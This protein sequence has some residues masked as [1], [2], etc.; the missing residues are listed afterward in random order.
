MTSVHGVD[1]N[2][3]LPLLQAELNTKTNPNGHHFCGRLGLFWF[4]TRFTKKSDPPSADCEYSLLRRMM[5]ML[6][7]N[8]LHLGT[9]TFYVFTFFLSRKEKPNEKN[10]EKLTFK[11]RGLSGHFVF[12][13]KKNSANAVVCLKV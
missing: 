8:R 7:N 5:N 4:S 3:C 11:N 2:Q 9:I 13:A 6:E 1:Y 10:T 12:F